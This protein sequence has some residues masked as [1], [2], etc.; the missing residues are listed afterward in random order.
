MLG[1]KYIPEDVKFYKNL[2]LNHDI[3]TSFYKIYNHYMTSK[4]LRIG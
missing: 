2:S 4:L 1:I 3:L